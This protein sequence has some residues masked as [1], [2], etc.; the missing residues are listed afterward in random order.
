MDKFLEAADAMS[1]K[2]YIRNQK[3]IAKRDIRPH[4][5]RFKAVAKLKDCTDRHDV[6][7]IYR[8]NDVRLNKNPTY[9][10]KSSK[11]KAKLAAN[12]DTETRI[13][14]QNSMHTWVERQK[15]VRD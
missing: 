13:L 6:T 11:L 5:H 12:M 15:D 8:C 1:D 3:K 9:V 4:G 2:Q 10:F 7:L 14:C